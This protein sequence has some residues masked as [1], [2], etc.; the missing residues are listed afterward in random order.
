MK[1]DGR[2]ETLWAEM[3]PNC[4]G[5]AACEQIVPNWHSYAEGDMQSGD[6]GDGLELSAA[7]FP[8]GTI[9][10]VLEPVCTKCNEVPSR[11]TKPET[12]I[13]SEG[14]EVTEYKW[15]CSCDFDWRQEALDLY[16]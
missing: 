2:R 14:G 6:D 9:V 16:A 5:G 3:R 12:F 1:R 15:T 13:T 11:S 4:Y 7:C 10:V 8:P